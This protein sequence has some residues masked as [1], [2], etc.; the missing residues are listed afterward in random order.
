MSM[1][2]TGEPIL[3]GTEEWPDGFEKSLG[4]FAQCFT[5]WFPG[6]TLPYRHVKLKHM[7]VLSSVQITLLEKEE[8]KKRRKKKKKKKRG[9][10]KKKKRR[11]EKRRPLKLFQA[12]YEKLFWI[13]SEIS[14]HRGPKRRKNNN[15]LK[16]RR[17]TFWHYLNS[18]LSPKQWG[19]IKVQMIHLNFVLA[20]VT[21]TRAYNTNKH[22]RTQRNGAD[23]HWRTH[24]RMQE[25]CDKFSPLT[26]PFS[27]THEIQQSQCEC[28]MRLKGLS[29]S[30]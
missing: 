21:R 18:F 7:S 10:K 30:S 16:T 14:V 3:E 4:S 20:T 26:N 22:A 6:S 12:R 11:K 8:K 24:A 9:E 23:P 5:I 29:R 13:T 27:D 19:E 17:D 25:W 1:L 28:E 2:I 15:N